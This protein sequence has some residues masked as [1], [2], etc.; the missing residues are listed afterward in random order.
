IPGFRPSVPVLAAAALLA[1]A[2]TSLS[3]VP[4]LAAPPP[5]R[6]P[7]RRP[8]APAFPAGFDWL[9]TDAPLDL[10]GKLKGHVVILDFWTYCCINCIHI[11]PDLKYLEQKYA[12]RPVAIVGVHAA[13]FTAEAKPA[14]VKQ[15]IGRYRIEHPVVVDRDQKIWDA[16][17]ARSWPTLVVIDSRGRLVGRLSGEGHRDLL[18]RVVG[19]LLEEG[20]AQGTLAKRPAALRRRPVVPGPEGLAFPGKVMADPRGKRLV[21]A[22]S[23]HDRILLVDPGGKVK[24]VIGAGAPG[25]EDGSFAKARFANP[26]GLAVDGQVIY[27]AD[28]DN[29]AIRRIDLAGGR[30]TTI[31]G[32]GRQSRDRRGG[33]KGR[34]QGLA[35]PWAL[36]LDGGRL[37]IAMAGTH[38]LW[39]HDLETGTTGVWVGSGREAILDGPAARAALAQ[40]S[41]LAVA[42]GWLYFADSEGSA[43]RRAQLE[44]GRVETLIGAEGQAGA[45]FVFGDAD[46]PW[47]RARLQHA[48]GVTALPGGRLAV[49]DTYNNKVRILDLEARSATTL[50]G[51]EGKLDEP[52]GLT[53]LD[54]AIYVAD[55][56]NHRIVRLDPKSGKATVVP[57]RLEASGR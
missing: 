10:A 18:D 16:Y 53:Y 12:D 3:L 57:I 20:E 1:V 50:Y 32:T 31:A 6:L 33:A 22:D 2:L 46:G 14:N 47:A 39:R 28:T 36:A 56:N 26:Q 30:V 35:S 27:V 29:H 54:G 9:N 25:F 5:L 8:P 38:Q 45:L 51:G 21:I 43:V 23:N 19:R 48:L 41:G 37:L 13:K 34:E 44:D 42:D 52:A 40:P 17:G 7:A 4:A 49:A 11:L 15:A 24:Q 55:T